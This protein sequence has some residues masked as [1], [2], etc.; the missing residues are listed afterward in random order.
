MSMET[1]LRLAEF[2]PLASN[3][4]LSGWGEPLLNPSFIKMVEE[5]KKAGGQVGFTTNAQLL[6]D[7]LAEKLVLLE[8]DQIGISLA[9]ASSMTHNCLRRG[10]K[11]K[12]LTDRLNTLSKIKKENA[13]EKPEVFLFYMMTRRNIQE[14]PQSIEYAA[15]I[16][17]SGVI[18]T[19]LD[20]VGSPIQ[21]ELRV[22][23]SETSEDNFRSLVDK[24]EEEALCRGIYF[25]AF[26]LE[27][28]ITPVCSEDP[29]NNL[30]VSEDGRVSPCVYLNLP[31]D[32]L[33]RIFHGEKTSFPRVFFG[34][35]GEKSLLET[36]SDPE[37][38]SFR[39]KFEKR[40]KGLKSDAETPLPDIC[41]T[42]YKA[43]GI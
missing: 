29:L 17:A 11:F 23:S 31:V 19:N 1:Y 16:G 26:P 7:D 12:G 21:D 40:K 4:Y 10:S 20:Y 33:H 30:Y 41:K 8:T 37:Y 35:I 18:A 3:V 14:L 24:A 38:A 22:F 2:F 9:G 6:K 42:C 36:W 34:D 39:K 27:E 28:K 43:Y 25:H 13:S 32:E 15:K 5:A